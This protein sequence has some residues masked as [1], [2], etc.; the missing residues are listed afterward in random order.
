MAQEIND[1]PL[2]LPV[3][4][5]NLYYQ[6][7]LLKYMVRIPSYVYIVHSYDPPLEIDKVCQFNSFSSSELN[8]RLL[9]VL[10][11]HSIIIIH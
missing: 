4:E 8:Y 9:A 6:S 1:W 7:A 5:C 11:M 2:K 10:W 3:P